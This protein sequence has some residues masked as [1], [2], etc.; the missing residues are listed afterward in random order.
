MSSASFRDVFCAQRGV[1][2]VSV[3]ER[4]YNKLFYHDNKKDAGFVSFVSGGG[5]D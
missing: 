2:S 1:L 5:G 3:R 4:N